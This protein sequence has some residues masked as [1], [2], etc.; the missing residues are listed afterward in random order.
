MA[1]FHSLTVGRE[2]TWTRDRSRLSQS[3]VLM[4]AV[5]LVAKLGVHNCYSGGKRV[6]EWLGVLEQHTR[7]HNLDRDESKAL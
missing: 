7:R 5:S 4:S 1:T 6:A 3:A 2:A